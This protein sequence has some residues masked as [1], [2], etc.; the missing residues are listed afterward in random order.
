MIGD[1]VAAFLPLLLVLALPFV[2]EVVETVLAGD[3]GR[4]PVALPLFG[5]LDDDDDLV[6]G[7][8]INRK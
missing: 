7:G 2:V 8:I 3:L 4:A 5:L 6:F 1:D